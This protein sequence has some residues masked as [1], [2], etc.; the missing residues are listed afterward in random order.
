MT[1]L[2]LKLSGN[3]GTVIIRK[4][5]IHD[6]LQ[7]VTRETP[8]KRVVLYK[9]SN[10]GGVPKVGANLYCTAVYYEVVH[11]FGDSLLSRYEAISLDPHTV[12]LFAEVYANGSVIVL[13]QEI[14][15][16]GMFARLYEAESIACDI[17]FLVSVSRFAIYVMSLATD[18]ATKDELTSEKTMMFAGV[19]I[20]KL[21]KMLNGF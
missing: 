3:A 4:K 7:E 15:P 12:K 10:G 21:K 14:Y 9:I 18:A 11:P 17:L 2:V 19:V 1:F 6:I 13:P 16:G 8:A 5:K 20:P